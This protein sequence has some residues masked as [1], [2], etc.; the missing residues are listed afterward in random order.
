MGLAGITPARVDVR[1]Q[2]GITCLRW[3]QLPGLPRHCDRF[4]EVFIR[5]QIYD[6]E[7]VIRRRKLGRELNRSQ[8]LLAHHGYLFARVLTDAAACRDTFTA[9]HISV[10]IMN[11]VVLRRESRPLQILFGLGVTFLIGVELAEGSVCVNEAWFCR[12]LLFEISTRF[13][14]Q[15]DVQQQVSEVIICYSIGDC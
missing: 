10:K 2:E 4:V 3:L 8:Q 14:W 13:V 1:K 15:S 9:E 5:Y 6:S 11:L 7:E 12:N